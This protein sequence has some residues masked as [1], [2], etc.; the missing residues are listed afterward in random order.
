MKSI[1]RSRG[2]NVSW[3][4]NKIRLMMCFDLIH[5]RWRA[6]RTQNLA[7]MELQHL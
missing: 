7:D 5:K 6:E 4:T 3:G 2:T 1:S